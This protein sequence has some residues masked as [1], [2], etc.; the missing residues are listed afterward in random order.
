M[1]GLRMNAN[2]RRTARIFFLPVLVGLLSFLVAMIPQIAY[3]DESSWLAHEGQMITTKNLYGAG[4]Q[5]TNA[6]IVAESYP[7]GASTVILASATSFPDA[8]SGSTLSSILDAPIVLVDKASL[9]DVSATTIRSLKAEKLIVL[10]SSAAISDATVVKAKTCVSKPGAT[11]RLGGADRYKTNA[12]IY[13]YMTKTLGYAF[14]DEIILATGTNFADALSISS[15]AAWA[16]KPVI[17]CGISGIEGTLRTTLKSFKGSVLVCGSEAAVSKANASWF[18]NNGAS[19]NRKGGALR[20]NTSVLLAEYAVSKGMKSTGLIIATSAN[21]PD[22][23]SGAQLGHVAVLPIILVNN[24]QGLSSSEPIYSY[25]DTYDDKITK[26]Y[27]LGGTNVLNQAKRTG[28]KDFLDAWKITFSYNGKTETKRCISGQVPAVPHASNYSDAA[29]NYT[30]TGWDKTVVAATKD[31]TYTARYTKVDRTYTVTW[32]GFDLVNPRTGI[33]TYGA[34]IKQTY[35]YGQAIKA[36]TFAVTFIS[37]QDGE[38]WY[39]PTYNLP[40]RQGGS[41]CFKGWDKVFKNCTGNMVINAK[42][43]QV[44]MLDYDG[45]TPSKPWPT[46]AE[47]AAVLNTNSMVSFNTNYW[48]VHN[49]SGSGEKENIGGYTALSIAQND[50]GAADWNSNVWRD[51]KPDPSARGGYRICYWF[52]DSHTS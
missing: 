22:A 2:A 31:T 23:L 38:P 25:L 24:V 5:Q 13:A 21:Y 48:D 16:E 6:E 47:V 4:R 49:G 9:S 32:K 15:Y 43:V 41:Y 52:I 42:W 10:G 40:Q 27:Y 11:V 7:A 45:K 35:K 46:G 8:L 37:P 28:I 30:F 29:T 19:I 17:L 18:K 36:P 20:E 14:S 50:Y 44:I 3:A 12:A 34:S 1:R 33:I 51:I 26:I 39:K